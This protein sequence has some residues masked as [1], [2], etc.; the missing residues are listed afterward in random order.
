MSDS[1]M[2]PLGM[3]VFPNTRFQLRIFE[4]RYIRL[5][6]D[7]S[8]TD[9]KFGVCL[10]AK[11]HEVG[12][13]DERYQYGTIS[14]IENISEIPSGQLLIQCM[15][16]HRIEVTN[17]LSDDPYPKASIELSEAQDVESISLQHLEQLR[18]ILERTY[19]NVHKLTGVERP[20]LPKLCK[21]SMEGIYEI[22]E[23]SFLGPHDRYQV[24]AANTLQ[25][26]FHTLKELMIGIDEIYINELKIR[27]QHG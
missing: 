20:P 22:A 14:K 2:F 24:L 17:W 16:Q 6:E 23:S 13:G 5:V 8:T 25:H 27:N 11:G 21:S 10:I 3:V 9:G 26:R 19:S 15:G 1:P 4:K 12:G 18:A 7:C